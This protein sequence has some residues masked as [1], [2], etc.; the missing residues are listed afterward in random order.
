MNIPKYE[1]SH[2]TQAGIPD[3]F[4]RAFISPNEKILFEMTMMSR[5]MGELKAYNGFQFPFEEEEK[6]KTTTKRIRARENKSNPLG[7]DKRSS[8][9]II[10]NPKKANVDLSAIVLAARFRPLTPFLLNKTV[11]LCTL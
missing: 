9:K 11:I 7:L 4:H 10:K 6:K 2:S 5:I 3:C 8:G 1:H